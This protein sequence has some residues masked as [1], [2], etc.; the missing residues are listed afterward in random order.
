MICLRQ[1]LKIDFTEDLF[2]KEE[3][4]FVIRKPRH[5]AGSGGTKVGEHGDIRKGRYH[6]HGADAD[7]FITCAL[8]DCAA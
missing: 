5:T 6:A 2:V 7:A 4:L 8:C 3:V 1:Y